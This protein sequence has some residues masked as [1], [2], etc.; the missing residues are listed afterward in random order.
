MRY[1]EFAAL[2][3]R[4]ATRVAR[5]CGPD[6]REALEHWTPARRLSGDA[7]TALCE[8][9]TPPL[10]AAA[11]QR[12]EALGQEP[13]AGGCFSAS[14]ESDGRVVRLHFRNVDGPGVLSLER[15]PARRREL[16]AALTAIAARAPRAKTLRCGSWLYHLTS[17]RRLFPPFL[18]DTAV[19]V[20]SD[21]ELTY[22]ALWGQFLRADG[23]LNQPRAASFE[24][25]AAG[26]RAP[27][28]LLE[29]F[30][31]SKLELHAPLQDVIGWLASQP[32]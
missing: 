18:L 2:H 32:E 30:P 14:T 6:R 13:S 3:L 20:R 8:D 9:P 10:L 15:M 24:A 1:E 7:W 19:P 28:S 11:Y 17:Y 31:L 26:A 23:R 12:Q 21:G 25:A 5:V 4:Y 27:A 16:Q 22:L 29:A